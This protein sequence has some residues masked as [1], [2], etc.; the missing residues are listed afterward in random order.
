MLEMKATDRFQ[1]N[2]D[3]VLHGIEE[4]NKY[5]LFNIKTG[6]IYNLNDVSMQILE[7]LK[8]GSPLD[9]IVTE[10][11]RQY[12]AEAAIIIEDVTEIL[13]KLL[14]KNIIKKVEGN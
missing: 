1:L 7:N 13:C 3:Y 9:Y 8:E 4:L 10:L 5:W 2:T 14:E 12:A 6:D 11:C